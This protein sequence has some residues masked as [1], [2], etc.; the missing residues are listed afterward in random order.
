MTDIKELEREAKE[1]V[2]ATIFLME[3][4]ARQLRRLDTQLHNI[5]KILGKIND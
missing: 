5:Y 4:F 1:T 2:E 3:D